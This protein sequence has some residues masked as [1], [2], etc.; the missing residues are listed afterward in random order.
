MDA[1]RVRVDL[2]LADGDHLP[3]YFPAAHPAE[4]SA[5]PVEAALRAQHLA[6][7]LRDAL[8]TSDW[9]RFNAA[10]LAMVEKRREGG[11]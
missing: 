6:W 1:E 9:C 10:M 5:D 8:S 7:K 3:P 4:P 11:R 2:T